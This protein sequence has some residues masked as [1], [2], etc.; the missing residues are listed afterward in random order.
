MMKELLPH[1]KSKKARTHYI[2]MS[3]VCKKFSECALSSDTRAL[4][5]P[6]FE[7]MVQERRKTQIAKKNY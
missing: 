6:S 3:T 1:K 4:G 2:T 7:N 5:Y